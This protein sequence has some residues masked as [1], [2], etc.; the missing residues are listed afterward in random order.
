MI[1]QNGFLDQFNK[2]GCRI[3]V[4]NYSHWAGLWWTPKDWRKEE[5]NLNN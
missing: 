1:I 3:K 5:S 2:P 4:E